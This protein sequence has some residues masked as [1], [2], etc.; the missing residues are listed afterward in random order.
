MYA[1]PDVQFVSFCNG[2]IGFI[3]CSVREDCLGHEL[4]HAFGMLHG[5][6]NWYGFDPTEEHIEAMRRMTQ[7]E[8]D[9]DRG[10]G[11]LWSDETVQSLRE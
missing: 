5:R 1:G 7:C 9:P 4:G 10:Y 3:T 6:H 11:S 2:P 8:P